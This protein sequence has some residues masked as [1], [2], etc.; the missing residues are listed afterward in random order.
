MGS[1]AL[2]IATADGGWN[3]NVPL[4]SVGDWIMVGHPTNGEVFRVKANNAP[5]IFLG[6]VAD[7][8]VDAS[9][10]A[11]GLKHATYE[12]QTLMLNDTHQPSGAILPSMG[13]RLQFRNAITYVTR[14]GGDYGC[15]NIGAT[16]DEVR[17]ELMN[18]LTIDEVVVTKSNTTLSGVVFTVTFT[19]DMLRGNVP[20]INIIDI[21]MN[22]CN[23]F[24]AIVAGTLRPPTWSSNLCQP[25]IPTL[26]Q[27]AGGSCCERSHGSQSR[28]TQPNA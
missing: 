8:T 6:S 4:L 11:V 26:I 13:F 1:S 28:G 3:P 20:D 15:L 27:D 16:A 7:P 5:L 19:G 25:V 18:L 10:S 2:S 14:A 22:G 17:E 23:N 24:N 12:V 9:L 21:G